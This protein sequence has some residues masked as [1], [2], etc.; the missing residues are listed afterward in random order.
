[1]A[2]EEKNT[3]T[4]D[5]VTD[6]DDEAVAGAS[7]EESGQEEHREESI[8]QSYPDG[9]REKLDEAEKAYSVDDLLRA[10]EI[11]LQLTTMHSG[12]DVG[13]YGLARVYF[14]ESSFAESAKAY[15]RCLKISPSFG[16]FQKFFYLSI[17]N[18]N[19]LY[20]MAQA[21]YREGLNNESL[22]YTDKLV[23]MEISP[24]IRNK[25]LVLREELTRLIHKE[26]DESSKDYRKGERTAGILTNI[27]LIIAVL[28]I[29]ALGVFMYMK[30][31]KTSHI[32]KGKN[33]FMEASRLKNDFRMNEQGGPRVLKAFEESEKI[34]TAVVQ[35][36]P[37]NAEAHFWLA[38]NYRETMEVQK[39]LAHK[40]TP[41]EPKNDLSAK[42]EEHLNKA[43]EIDPN[44]SD[45][46]LYLGILKMEQKNTKKAKEFF[47]Q[48]IKTA[49]EYYKLED[50]ET[51]KKR[52]EVV[53][54]SKQ[55]LRYLDMDVDV[56]VDTKKSK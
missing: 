9:Y 10:K 3:A 18:P 29:G 50:P 27:F 51:T 14:K 30:T 46:Y 26:I 19:K 13:W 35:K 55:Y 37:D 17:E 53:N 52:S 25:V 12:V 31:P 44:Y 15:G 23:E 41:G 36:E 34:L 40:V 4:E 32:T 45:A 22:K 11:Y 28:A 42:I 33:A 54:T 47:E 39:T 49:K 48:A 16:M 24:D 1:M 5:S 21:L 38:R 56:D 7:S 43:I 8:V 2:E 20:E 6:I